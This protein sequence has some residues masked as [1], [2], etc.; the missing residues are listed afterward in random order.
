MSWR[1]LKWLS[2]DFFTLHTEGVGKSLQC[3]NNL[4]LL[5]LTLYLDTI[6]WNCLMMQLNRHHA[7][8]GTN[9]FWYN[10]S[11]GKSDYCWLCVHSIPTL[12]ITG[13]IWT[14]VNW[15]GAWKHM[16]LLK[17]PLLW[18]C[19]I[20][21]TFRIKS[22]MYKQLKWCPDIMYFILHPKLHIRILY[23]HKHSIISSYEMG[24]GRG[25]GVNKLLSVFSVFYWGSSNK[26][27]IKM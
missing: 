21:R 4:E 23:H 11:E 20:S 1:S 3:A 10:Y 16:V 6:S 8:R 9:L 5:S 22:F 2:G 24:W 13:N 15:Q 18:I 14:G 25:G 27:S 26:I 19:G 7:A 17:E 12:V